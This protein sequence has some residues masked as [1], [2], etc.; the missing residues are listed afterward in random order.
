MLKKHIEVIFVKSVGAVLIAVGV[1]LLTD[2]SFWKV[3]AV[4]FL[5]MEGYD[6]VSYDGKKGGD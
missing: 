1:Y 2:L 5:F 4:A 3:L 6:C